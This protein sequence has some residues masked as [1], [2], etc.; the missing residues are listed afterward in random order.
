[1][2]CKSTDEGI[3][4]TICKAVSYCNNASS[5]LPSP[6]SL[7]PSNFASFARAK[8]SCLEASSFKE[9]WHLASPAAAA[10]L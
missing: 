1:M 9:S 4:G 8:V 6:N 3:S 5:Y 7:L 2:E 10:S